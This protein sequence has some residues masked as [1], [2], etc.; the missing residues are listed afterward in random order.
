MSMYAFSDIHGNY[1]IFQNI[2]KKIK[3]SDTI[4]FLGDA[5]DRGPDGWKI[6]KELLNHP[7][8]EY[9]K[10]NHE[11]MLI[12][13]FNDGDS[14]IWFYNG[15]RPTYRDA[16]N[17]DELENILK[18]IQKLPYKKTIQIENKTLLLSH[19]GC[20]IKDFK[21]LNLHDSIWDRNHLL[22]DED[23]TQMEDVY[24]IHGHTPLISAPLWYNGNDI[25]EHY[26]DKNHHKCD[27]DAGTYNT[28]KTILMKLDDFSYEIIE[29]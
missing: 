4:Y 9:I 2:L 27:I 3:P 5:I 8:V 28:N 26:P 25:G 14:A 29:K 20:L 12:D 7:Q 13:Y 18:K 21:D 23:L 17:D 6:L 16:I 11:Q 1:K 10:G 24:L 19:A 15:G 22:M